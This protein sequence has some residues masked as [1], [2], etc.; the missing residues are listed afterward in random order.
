MLRQNRG[1]DNWFR[2]LGRP[3]CRCWVRAAQSLGP[4]PELGNEK[5]GHAW[6]N[7]FPRVGVDSTK[8]SLDL[9]HVDGLPRQLFGL[10]IGVVG[11]VEHGIQIDPRCQM[12]QIPSVQL[13]IFVS[14]AQQLQQ[15]AAA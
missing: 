13:H 15:T 9:R 2:V 6:E 8:A 5:K 11:S 10:P 14:A 4:K 7:G 12:A 1:R 3:D